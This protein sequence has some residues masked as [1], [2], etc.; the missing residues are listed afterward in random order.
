MFF[1]EKKDIALDSVSNYKNIQYLAL[2]D[3]HSKVLDV[4]PWSN[5]L[6][7][8]GVSEKFGQIIGWHLPLLVWRPLGNPQ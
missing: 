7:L 6:H 8:H 2:A 5:F 3:L 1:P 4:C